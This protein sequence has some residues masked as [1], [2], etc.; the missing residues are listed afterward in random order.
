M[1]NLKHTILSEHSFFELNK[2][3]ISN[4]HCRKF[5]TERNQDYYVFERSEIERES[6]SFYQLSANYFIGIDWLEKD[7]Y[8]FQVEPKVNTKLTEHFSRLTEEE[9]VDKTVDVEQVFPENGIED[10]R[11]L[12][13]L[14]MLLEVM[15]HPKVSKETKNLVKIY[16]NEPQISIN[17]KQDRLTPFL[18]AQF[19]QILKTIVKKGLKK[20]YYK[21]QENLNNKVK[22]KILVGQHIRQNVLKNR[23]T[24]TYCEYQEF[25][26]DSLE[27]RFLKKVRSFCSAYVEN[28]KA[29]FRGNISALQNILSF[30]NPVFEQIGSEF[31]EFQLK[32]FKYNPFFKEYSEAFTIG[33]YILKKFAYNISKVAE[34]TVSTPPFWIDM[35]RLFELY[36]YTQLL[37]SNPLLNKDIHY[38][39]STYGNALDFLISDENNEMIIDTKYKLHYQWGE[40]HED[41]RQVAGYARL[42][43][44]RSK[45]KIQDDKIIDCLIVYPDLSNGVELENISIDN[46]KVDWEPIN[47][48]HKV[49]KLGVKLPEIN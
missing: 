39:F 43:K 8:S 5:K 10:I 18:V 27:N 26:V 41:I 45:L 30:T 42:K 4:L 20:S 47:A 35:P 34:K 12:D 37:N 21:K 28:N 1:S 48:Y 3:D 32:Q 24:Q 33:Q 22:G 2:E 29:L 15:A 7:K 38:Q 46:I 6:K 11:E 36:F 31:D 14:K 13:Y 17:Q 19:L 9:E 49:Y 40:V 23:F 44:V 16:W 25:G